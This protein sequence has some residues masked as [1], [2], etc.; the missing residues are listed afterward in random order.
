MDINIADCTKPRAELLGKRV[1]AAWNKNFPAVP[2]ITAPRAKRELVRRSTL[3]V[4]FI[5]DDITE[6]SDMDSTVHPDKKLA[7]EIS[8]IPKASSSGLMIIP[9]PMPD[10]APIVDAAVLM[11]SMTAYI[12]VLLTSF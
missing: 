6:N 9:P 2:P 4:F 8:K 12:K 11:H 7:A 1:P 3:D 5:W 10:I